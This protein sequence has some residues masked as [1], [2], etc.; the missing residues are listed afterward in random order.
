MPRQRHVA[1]TM[2]LQRFGWVRD[3]F[4]TIF[5]CMDENQNIPKLQGRN[6][7]LNL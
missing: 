1:K 6:A 5:F 7:Y 2:P 3:L 4:K